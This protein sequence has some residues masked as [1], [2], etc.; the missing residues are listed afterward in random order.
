MTPEEEKAAADKARKDAD[1][2]RER[3]DADAGQKLDTLLTHLDSFNT[4]MDSMAKRMDAFEEDK[5]ARDDAAKADRMDARKDAFSKRK[6]DDD[7]KTYCDRHDAEE[8]TEAERMKKEG[9][10]EKTAKD[11]AKKARKDA[12]EMEAKDRKDAED[13][14]EEKDRKDSAR[15]DA[16]SVTA[17]RTEVDELRK[18]IP[19]SLTD[20]DFSKLS[21]AQ[22]RAD[23]VFQMFGKQ[24]PRPM[25]AE[26]LQEYRL[27]IAN[28][29]KE[30]SP[31]WKA[32]NLA[33]IAVDDASFDVIEKSLYDEARRTAMD[34]PDLT[35]GELRAITRTDSTTNRLV[36]EFVGKRS[37]VHDFSQPAQYVTKIITDRH[38]T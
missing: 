15:A 4:K 23:G 6:D 21:Q 9:A 31:T 36:T 14:K 12:E 27:R 38:A 8:E 16:A 25:N 26:T 35:N 33:V 30:H 5:K 17:I 3:A 34:P 18:R 11:K 28:D 2:K 20:E 10:D 1:E 24:A 7:D 13:E 19:K 29:L 37:F 22:A 32:S